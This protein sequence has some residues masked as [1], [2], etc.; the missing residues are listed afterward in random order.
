MKEV[1]RKEKTGE[2]TTIRAEQECTGG[3]DRNMM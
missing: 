3:E 2:E 1:I